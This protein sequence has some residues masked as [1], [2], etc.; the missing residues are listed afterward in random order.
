MGVI[1]RDTRSLDYNSH[2]ISSSFA[3]LFPWTHTD[4]WNR[5]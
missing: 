5:A 1:K 2:K 3:G 4:A